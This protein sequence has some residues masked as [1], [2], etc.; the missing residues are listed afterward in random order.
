MKLAI[1]HSVIWHLRNAEHY[2]FHYE[3]IDYLQGNL[4]GLATV[5]KSYL[6]YKS[7]FD[8]ENQIF[9][10]SRKMKDTEAIISA[11]KL[12]LSILSGL[13]SAI[14]AASKS[15]KKE[16]QQAGSLL[17]FSINP[18]K[19]IRYI[20]R[21]SRTAYI[22]N[23]LEDLQSDEYKKAVNSID[24]AEALELLEQANEAFRELDSQ[25]Y[26][27][28][29]E[30]KLKGNMAGIKTPVNRAF[31]NLLTEIDLTYEFN[32]RSDN[33]NTEL[34]ERLLLII[35]EINAILHNTKRII[36]YRKEAS[37]EAS[38]LDQPDT[39]VNEKPE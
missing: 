25:R 9:Q 29:W 16:H 23:L 33:Y 27:L 30:K 14:R 18:Y 4:Q 38:A 12:R 28:N 17:E 10:Q 24:Q 26:N 1:N 11:D 5:E 37:G 20:G 32:R 6:Y 39:P 2:N 31:R 19:R 36:A 35:Q 3:I 22:I 13:F 34:E 7:L 15:S 8:K 21:L